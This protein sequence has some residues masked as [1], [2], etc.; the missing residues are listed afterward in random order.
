MVLR[1]LC[2]QIDCYNTASFSRVTKPKHFVQ[3]HNPHNLLVP[4][5]FLA[6]HDPHNLHNPYDPHDPYISHN[7]HDPYDPQDPLYRETVNF[8]KNLSCCAVAGVQ[9]AVQSVTTLA[10]SLFGASFKPH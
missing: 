7:L 2:D 9:A 1:P 6:F 5:L 8:D 10:K 4:P 3:S